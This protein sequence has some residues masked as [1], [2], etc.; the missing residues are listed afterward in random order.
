MAPAPTAPD[1]R[2]NDA[3][4][5]LAARAGNRT[6]LAELIARH[7]PLALTMCRRV[8]RSP[9]LAEDAV[10]EAC[11]QAMLGLDGLREP[12]RFGPWLIGIALNVCRHTLR[13]PSID[14]L[15]ALEL[16]GGWSRSEIAAREPGPED[17]AES[18]EIA[19]RV[20]G[21]VLR[22]PPGQRSAVIGFYLSGLSYRETAAE[23]GIGV[24]AVRTRLHK[25]RAALRDDLRSLWEELAMDTTDLV[26]MR[27]ADIRRGSA[28]A[29]PA[30]YLVLLE[31]IDGARRLPIW[32]GP[33]EGM[34]L[35][36]L[37]EQLEF[38]RPLGPQF[39]FDA[40]QAVGAR[41]VEVRIDRLAE[42]TFFAVAMIQGPGG[43]VEVDAR[44]SDALSAALL[45]DARVT[46]RVDL[47]NGPDEQV[48]AMM[49]NLAQKFPE[50]ASD[51]VEA[52]SAARLQPNA[53]HGSAAAAPPA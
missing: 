51:I 16:S 29:E 22:L 7:R 19:T 30:S 28:D 43:A 10:Q 39:M 32:I 5:V 3:G 12:Q 11:L 33:H 20:R 50:S 52:Q 18:A 41:V 34:I 15:S 36:F 45:A 2:I 8:L 42:K 46:A 38:P 49:D 26:E 24:T 53:Q 27:I 48:A 23:L 17:L 37:L 44:P 31:E 47:F 9:Q 35:A 40:L 25:A 14:S 4:L 6:S 1:A 21:A 13:Q